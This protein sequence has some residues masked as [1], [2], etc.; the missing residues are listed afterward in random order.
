MIRAALFDL[1]GTL[2]DSAGLIARCLHETL[3]DH[4]YEVTADTI[5]RSLGPATPRVV[6]ALTAAPPHEV[7]RIVEAFGRRYATRRGTIAKHPGADALLD[8]LARERIALALITNNPE[9]DVHALLRQLRWDARFEV[10]LGADSGAGRKPSAEPALHALD[11]LGVPPEDAAFIGDTETDMRCAL[12][13]GIPTRILVGAPR[14][15]PSPMPPDLPT[16]TAAGLLEVR[17][18][19]ER[20]RARSSAL[21]VADGRPA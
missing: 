15:A 8:W 9:V 10:V 20:L 19:L 4:G 7:D 16:Y 3:R 5:A 12:D 11:A 18:L 17:A 21:G 1:D 14:V 6:E 13:A 2:V